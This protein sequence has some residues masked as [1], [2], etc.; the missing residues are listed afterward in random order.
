[1]GLSGLTDDKLREL[2]RWILSTDCA[3]C[4]DGRDTGGKVCPVC[5]AKQLETPS[6]TTEKTPN[7]GE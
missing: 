1:M 3:Y 2:A 5:G 7:G 4:I 6:E